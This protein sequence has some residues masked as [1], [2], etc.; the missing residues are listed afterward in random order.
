MSR[1][2]LKQ[3]IEVYFEQSLCY[4]VLYVKESIV[5]IHFNIYT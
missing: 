5:G 4:E 3:N 2:P 1:T